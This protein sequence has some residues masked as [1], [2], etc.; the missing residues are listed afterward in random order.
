M[1]RSERKREIAIDRC[2]RSRHTRGQHGGR[3]CGRA[4]A[5]VDIRQPFGIALCKRYVD[6][7]PHTISHGYVDRVAHD[8]D[9]RPCLTSGGGPDCFSDRVPAGQ[10]LVRICLVDESDRKRSVR[11]PFL[12]VAAGKDGR[13]P[14]V[15]PSRRDHMEQCHVRVPERHWAGFGLGGRRTWQ[16]EKVKA[17]GTADRHEHR[18]ACTRDARYC[19]G[20]SDKL[21]VEGNPVARVDRCAR[22]VHVDREYAVAIK[23]ERQRREPFERSHQQSRRDDEHH[24]QRDLNNDEAAGQTCTCVTQRTATLFLERVD[25]CDTRRSE[26]RHGPEQYGCQAGDHDSKGQHAPI[27]REIQ[28]H[29]RD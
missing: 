3:S 5:D 15:E 1:K 14:G 18:P 22:H 17:S 27:E 7:R 29:T 6:S 26:R 9:D 8:S 16:V 11:I 12:D 25:R 4:N 24:R 19:G 28:H 21:V 23:P 10:E 13:A 2:Q 20:G